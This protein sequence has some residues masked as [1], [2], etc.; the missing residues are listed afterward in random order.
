MAAR[1]RRNDA[2]EDEERMEKSGARRSGYHAPT[3]EDVEDIKREHNT[4]PEG[5]VTADE[6]VREAR[7]AGELAEEPAREEERP[8]GATSLRDV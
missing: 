2:R 8:N 7:E 3:K 6:A 4:A 1:E 5:S